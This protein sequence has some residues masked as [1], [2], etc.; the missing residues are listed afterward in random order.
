MPTERRGREN[1]KFH[2]QAS[3]GLR[4]R[5]TM[6]PRLMKLKS[7][8]K[9]APDL[10][11]KTIHHLLTVELLEIAFHRLDERKAI[12]IDGVSKFRYA[13][14]LEANLKDLENRIQRG[15][16]QPLP[17]KQV[18]IPK[19]NGK[20]RPIAI[21]ALE[22]KIVQMAAAM[23]LDALYEPLFKDVSTGFRPRRG[24]HDAIGK[25]YHVLKRDGRPYVVDCDIQAFFDSM[26]HERLMEFLKKRISDKRFLRLIGRL[27]RMGVMT[28]D[29]DTK[30][31]EVGSPQGSVVSPIL[32][33]IYLHYVIDTWFEESHKSY[34]QQLVRYADDTVFCFKDASAAE[35]FLETLKS[36]LKENHL[37]LN[38]DKT[39]IVDFRKDAGNTF[40]FLGFSFYWGI[41]KDKARLLKTKTCAEKLRRSIHS[42]KDWIRAVRNKHKLR[43][44]WKQ[45]A[46]K[47]NGHYAYYGTTVNNKLGF[48]Y[49]TCLELLHKWLNRRSQKKSMSWTAFQERLKSF[50]LP[51]PWGFRLV[52]LNQGVLD[53]AI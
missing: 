6:T 48:Y 24:C 19:A 31:N 32:A 20:M 7:L 1:G 26:D 30:I 17:A 33:N 39:K 11:F 10:S 27:L 5:P 43:V 34:N 25:L 45:A 23:I 22:D 16:Y 2:R 12:G 41:G 37:E 4:A 35:T 40:N 9:E 46:E 47:I 50:P 13:R 8:A 36:R 44:L 15:A 38:E 18:L 49:K 3:P 42:F 28:Q 53:Y 14:H 21:S 51:K 52:D 29:G